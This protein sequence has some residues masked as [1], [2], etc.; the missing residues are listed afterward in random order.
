MKKIDIPTLSQH[1][2][3]KISIASLYNYSNEIIKMNIPI[4]VNKV[5]ENSIYEEK[6][7]INKIA[8]Y[9]K[10]KGINEIFAGEFSEIAYK[11]SLPNLGYKKILEYKN[12]IQEIHNIRILSKELFNERNWTTHFKII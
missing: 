11:T 8:S 5:I 10:G 2:E 7:I 9:L 4:N 3:G 1:L 12:Y 6:N